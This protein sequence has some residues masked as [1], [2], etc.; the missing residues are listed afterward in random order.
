MPK[1]TKEVD[2]HTE[3]ET[4]IDDLCYGANH[5]RKKG[6]RHQQLNIDPDTKRRKCKNE[7]QQLW[8]EVIL[9]EEYKK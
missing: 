2:D 1:E 7:T 8:M 6:W 3:T 9:L 5:N 4:L